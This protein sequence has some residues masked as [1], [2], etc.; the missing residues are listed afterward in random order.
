MKSR[1]PLMIKVFRNE[2]HADAFLQRGTLYCRNLGYFKRIEDGDGRGDPYEGVTDWLQPDQIEMRMKINTPD[3][4]EK[5]MP[6]TGLAG[7]VILQHD[8][9]DPLN[10]FCLYAIKI[11]EFEES[12][13]SEAERLLVVERINSM[14]KQLSTLSDEMQSMGH[15]AV[16]IHKVESF[17]DRVREVAAKQKMNCSRGAVKYY[18]PETFHGSFRGMECVFRKRNIYEYQ[19]E[20]RFCFDSHAPTDEL[21]LHVG[22]LEDIAVKVQTSEINQKLQL[23]LADEGT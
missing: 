23:K 17:I 19:S 22:S 16:L 9:Y 18:D 3:G 21:Y 8:G 14:L 2:E 11:P 7:P 13:D 12:F 4:A 6:I 20:Y 1:I 15:F 10:L 5:E